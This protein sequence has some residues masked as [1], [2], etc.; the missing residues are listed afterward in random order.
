MNCEATKAR[1]CRSLATPSKVV[2]AKLLDVTVDKGAEFPRSH[3]EQS[4][5]NESLTQDAAPVPTAKRQLD[6]TPESDPSPAKRARLTRTDAQRPGV[7]KAEQTDKTTLQQP[8]PRPPKRSYASFL[9]DFVDPV[10]SHPRPGSLHTF[11][12]EWL[13]SVGSDREKHCRSDSHLYHADHEPVSR[14]LTRSAPE[15]D[16]TLDTDGFVVP[17][18]PPSVRSRTSRV[19]SGD[20]SNRSSA[21]GIA[22][23]RNPRYRTTNLRFNHIHIVRHSASPLPDFVTSHIDSI[24]AR[25]HSPELSSD[26][27]NQ[28]I[29]RVETLT[30]GCT[31]DEVVKLLD[32]TIFPNPITDTTY[33]PGAGLMSN[34]N[35]LMAQH[36]VPTTPASPY[37]VTQP[38][39]DM[40]Y[41][42]SDGMGEAFTEPQLLAQ[43]MLHPWNVDYPTATSRGLS[44]PFFAIEVKAAGGTRGDL[45]VAIN[46]CAGAS[47]A[48]LNAASQLNWALQRCE[49]TERVDN[50]SYCIAVDNVIARLYISWRD[51]N[52]SYYL[53]Q[54]DDFV[55]SRPEE[56]QNFRKQVRNILDW[57]KGARL[58]QIRDALDI[59]L[60]ENRKSASK[61][62]KS[63]PPACDCSVAS[64]NQQKSSSRRSSSRSS[65]SQARIR[66]ADG[67]Y[68]RLDETPSEDVRDA[69]PSRPHQLLI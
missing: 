24:R 32:N 1:T 25:R 37:R 54:V 18:T 65:N 9:K 61:A 43:T 19:G 45:W 60:E 64:G 29:S 22:S 23:T 57:G 46:Q 36:L 28:A 14:Q 41:G 6:T 20:N 4:P 35:T 66:A 69:Q 63:R 47:A 17:L 44:F 52:L 33:G 2:Q 26:E 58:T 34:S 30:E 3:R 59:I 13:E 49:S 40:L 51:D 21:S 12:S 10:H 56:L 16:C 7:R 39:P 8:V 48:C 55:L 31:E 42:Y 27:L 50:L 11:V 53:Q 5:V 67:P 62:A 68:Q 38:K 15:M